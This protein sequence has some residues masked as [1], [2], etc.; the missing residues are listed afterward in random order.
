M[1]RLVTDS[2]DPYSRR[3]TFPKW[4]GTVNV[5]HEHRL[6]RY[7]P[8]FAGWTK[9]D[10]VTR[11]LAFLAK[12]RA[13]DRLYRLRVSH[14]LKTYGD[15]GPLISGVVREHFPEDVKRD[16]RQTAHV[17]TFALDASLAHWQ[18]GRRTLETWRRERDTLAR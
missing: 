3:F 8:E 9:A 11:A 15:H 6:M 7:L 14:A 2:P 18:A 17:Y 13:A 5:L 10:H 16:L 4:N 1:P 12:A